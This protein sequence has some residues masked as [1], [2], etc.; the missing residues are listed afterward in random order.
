LKETHVVGLL[1]LHFRQQTEITQDKAV[2]FQLHSKSKMTSLLTFNKG[3]I[4]STGRDNG[5]L[6]FRFSMADWA[7]AI[8]HLSIGWGKLF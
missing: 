2:N 7:S 4:F 1:C 6:R 5:F 3:W 8:A